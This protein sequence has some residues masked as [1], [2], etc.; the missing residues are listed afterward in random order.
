M[1]K[2]KKKKGKHRNY[3]SKAIKQK[4]IDKTLAEIKKIPPKDEPPE[5]R[6]IIDGFFRSKSKDKTWE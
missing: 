3:D 4:N 5:N 1:S 2:D 6:N